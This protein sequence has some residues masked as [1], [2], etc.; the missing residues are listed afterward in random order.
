MFI[1]NYNKLLKS[2]S[3]FA[4]K[5]EK[6]VRHVVRVRKLYLSQFPRQL[7]NHLTFTIQLMTHVI[8]V[9]P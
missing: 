9:I 8:S 6:Y 1:I 3:P 7:F 2:V 4:V 5:T